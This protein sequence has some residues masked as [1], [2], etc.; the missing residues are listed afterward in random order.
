[1]R[2]Q[3]AQDD[4]YETSN[5]GEG[6]PPPPPPPPPPTAPS[7]DPPTTPK[8]DT[9]EPDSEPQT[10][11]ET[12]N[13]EITPPESS[14]SEEDPPANIDKPTEPSKDV[15]PADEESEK[16]LPA[17]EKD[18]DEKTIEERLDE[19]EG[20]LEKVSEKEMAS[21]SNSPKTVVNEALNEDSSASIRENLP[22]SPCPSNSRS[23]SSL[24]RQQIAAYRD[25][26][27]LAANMSSMP[28]HEDREDSSS[29]SQSY[30]INA[31][32]DQQMNPYDMKQRM[33][34]PYM[35]VRGPDMSFGGI[36]REPYD[37]SGTEHDPYAHYKRENDPYSRE[38][39]DPYGRNQYM[40]SY[41]EEMPYSGFGI[42]R[43]MNPYYHASGG[44]FGI[45]REHDQDVL[46]YN[47]KRECSE[48]P[49]SF[50]DEEAAVCAMLGQQGNQGM[51]NQGNP[52]H[53]DMLQQHL[54]QSAPKKR[55]RKKKIK[56]EW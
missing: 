6:H 2:S 48:D 12:K 1:M 14:N 40:N 4:G 47:G 3:E 31:S 10:D 39:I 42:K 41:K 17:K 49:Y 52:L 55:G 34:Q 50:V 45:K 53:P 30:P 8:M 51:G 56:D 35:P 15:Q 46:G 33:P 29:Q 13:S 26:V 24:G 20:T 36:K 44:Q 21:A 38:N 22:S 25:G 16:P 7:V 37:M 28:V 11:S 32:M 23:N 27:D 54:M 19:V 9:P 5:G 18:E 43:D